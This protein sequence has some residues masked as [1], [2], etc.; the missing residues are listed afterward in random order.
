M[1]IF[2]K[3]EILKNFWDRFDRDNDK[4]EPDPERD[5]FIICS[6]FLLAGIFSIFFYRNIF[7]LKE[8]FVAYDETSATSTEISVRELSLENLNKTLKPWTEKEQ[9]YED[10]LER[11]SNFDFLR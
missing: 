11:G 5:W 3:K 4:T 6:F 7:G 10:I 9:N 2:T 8:A 1:R